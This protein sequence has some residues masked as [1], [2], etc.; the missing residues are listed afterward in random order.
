MPGMALMRPQCW[1]ARYEILGEGSQDAG[2]SHGTGCAGLVYDRNES[3]LQRIHRAP[4][5]QAPAFGGENVKSE[6]RKVHLQAAGVTIVS[7]KI[8]GA[9]SGHT[10]ACK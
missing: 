1:E 10:S 7:Q 3:P 5:V 4:H 6:T 9:R 8:G 2:D